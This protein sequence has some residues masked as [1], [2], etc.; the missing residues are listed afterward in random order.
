MRVL[1]G[2]REGVC[3]RV[4]RRRAPPR[5]WRRESRDVSELVSLSVE[6]SASGLRAACVLRAEKR[7][8][9]VTGDVALGAHLLRRS[10]VYLLD[11]V[12][13]CFEV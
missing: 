5:A 12:V 8:A 3:A 2:A 6:F 13:E 7:A 11:G 4:W 9:R 1:V 10:L